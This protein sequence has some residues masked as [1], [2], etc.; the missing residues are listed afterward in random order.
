[1]WLI[2][3]DSLEQRDGST[4]H[5]GWTLWLAVPILMCLWAN[6]HGSYLIGLILLACLALG[7]AMDAAIRERSLA[8][9]FSD[10]KVQRYAFL[11]ELAFV[12]T[13]I[14]PYGFQLLI[15]NLTFARN[16]NLASILE[17][18]PLVIL[19]IGGREFALSVIVLLG[20]WRWSRAPVSA[21][22]V[23]L[24]ALF[25]F[26][27]IQSLRMIGWYAPIFAW[28]TMPHLADVWSRVRPLP[29][30]EPEGVAIEGTD[31]KL[32]PG[33]SF[34]YTLVCGLFIWI[35]LAFSPAGTLVLNGKRR[36]DRQMFD[37]ASSPLA[38]AAELA[39]NPPEG[40]IFNPQHWGDWLVLKVPGIQP[41]VTSN[42]HLTPPHVWADYLR[43][44]EGK[45][46]WQ[47]V[48]DR[49]NV[50]MLVLDKVAQLDLT[51]AMKQTTGWS[52]VYEDER[53][54][55]YRRV[56]QAKTDAEGAEPPATEQAP[57][58]EKEAGPEKENAS[59]SSS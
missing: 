7:T 12:A 58:G 25:G 54:I 38:L 49:Y 31:Y 23:L 1:M 41:F 30:V 20:L 18:Q 36:T 9:I 15:Y 55:V 51:T 4:S 32:P 3:R 28:A 46:G 47:R 27:A 19:G 21:T 40:Q 24:L 10:G 22:Q 35:G 13:L 26:A 5:K 14:N 50:R 34:H 53:A 11:A 52:L 56:V 8:A 39:R 43:I 42:I 29:A 17:W 59:G 57:G 16:P 37:N 2:T 33:R 45:P 6:L 44:S 48:L